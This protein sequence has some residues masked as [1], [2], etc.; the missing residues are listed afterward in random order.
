MPQWRKLHTKVIDS[1]DVNE[2]PDFFKVAL[3]DR[4][5]L[6][7]DREGRGIY[8]TAW[9]RARA[10]PMRE[11]VTGAMI[12]EALEWYER[13]GMI[14]TY[15]FNGKKY[16]YIP[17]WHTYQSTLREAESVLPAPNKSNTNPDPKQDKLMTN[18]G[19]TPDKLTTNSRTDTDTEKD[20]EKDT[21]TEKES[22]VSLFRLYEN[23]IG[24]I[25]KSIADELQDAEREYPADWFPLVFQEAARQNKRSWAYCRAI[26]KR[27]K[28]EGVSSNAGNGRKPKNPDDWD[29]P[30]VN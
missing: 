23:E 24:V 9:I 14:V 21:D 28:V 25:S 27:W 12:T 19:L 16:F 7:L 6:I 4:F 5:V 30:E 2:M 17:T 11:D 3:W 29:Y 26:L 18:S 22:C 1:D 20:K 8:N 15:S 10:F 13:R